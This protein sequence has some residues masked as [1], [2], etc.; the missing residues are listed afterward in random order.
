MNID[1][2]II[3]WNTLA[4]SCK[5]MNL[6]YNYRQ[7]QE[8]RQSAVANIKYLIEK[9]DFKKFDTLPYYIRSCIRFNKKDS[10]ISKYE[11]DNMQKEEGIY[12]WS[13][14]YKLISSGSYS[15]VE[16]LCPMMFDIAVMN[17]MNIFSSLSKRDKKQKL[18]L[19]SGCVLERISDLSANTRTRK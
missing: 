13:H 17:I 3:R 10:L 18:K 14:I 1:E 11:E 2:E 7:M 12:V 9:N 19:L 8:V 6:A 15:D 4:R 5:S 16:E